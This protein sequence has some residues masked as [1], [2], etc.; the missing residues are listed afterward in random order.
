MKRIWVCL[1]LRFEVPK[2]VKLEML[3]RRAAL[4]GNTSLYLP[5]T[6]VLVGG[7]QLAT[8][9]AA[10]PIL[11]FSTPKEVVSHKDVRFRGPENKLLHFDPFFPKNK[12]LSVDF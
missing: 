12:K 2:D 1:Q 6:L 11:M 8:P 3:S 5:P 10:A 7:F 4:S 9:K